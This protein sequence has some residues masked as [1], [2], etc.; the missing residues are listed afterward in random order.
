LEE[1]SLDEARAQFETNFFGVVRM[2]KAV[3]PLGLRRGRGLTMSR[4]HLI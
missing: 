3:L 2:V 4:G 1:L